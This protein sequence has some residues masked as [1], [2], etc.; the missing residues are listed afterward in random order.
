MENNTN[1]H[2]NDQYN[3]VK[4]GPMDAAD[5]KSG[6]GGNYNAGVTSDDPE[7]KEKIEKQASLHTVQPLSQK[8]KEEQNKT[9]AAATEITDGEA[10]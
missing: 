3:R 2:S 5:E 7:E 9:G 1:H 10:G 4:P 6:L 8:Q